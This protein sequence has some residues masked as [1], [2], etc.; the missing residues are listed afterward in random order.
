LTAASLLPTLYK[1][2]PERLLYIPSQSGNIMKL[3]DTHCH[4]DVENF[5]ADRDAVIKRARHAGVKTIII[6][7]V[8]RQSWEHLIELCEQ[9]DDLHFALGLHPYFIDEH[10]E[11]DL[12]ELEA[13]LDQQPAIAVGEIGLDYFDKALNREKQLLFFETQVT[14]A[15]Q[16]QLPI[17]VHARK[18]YD[19]IIK[20]LK[21]THFTQGGIMHA[22][23]GSH[24]HADSLMKMGFK[25]GFGGMLTFERSTKLTKLACDLP[26]E[27]IVLET[28]APDMTVASHRGERNSPE[29][30]PEILQAL[31]TAR[32]QSMQQLAEQTTANANQVLRLS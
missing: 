22:F 7:A 9:D 14:I 30:L 15:Q 6:P 28:D 23:N 10:D 8:K 29:Y 24:Q 31:A 11:S 19:D 1:T 21:K 16:S 25:F 20:V 27:A 13:Y 4:I 32:Q 17:I 18:S 26:I 2:I 12:E 3:I 5:S